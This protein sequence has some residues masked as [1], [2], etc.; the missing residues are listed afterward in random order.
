MEKVLFHPIM[1][2]VLD[3]LRK[4]PVALLLVAL[5]L[6]YYA[7][8]S[9]RAP[10]LV[11][12]LSALGLI[13]LASYIGEGTEALAAHFGPRIGG[14]LNATFGNTAEL[15]I[16]YIALREGLL[17][18]VR[19]SITGSI[20]G[21]ILLVMGFSMLFGGFKFGKQKFDRSHVAS[22]AILLILA[23]LVLLMPS[24]L[25]FYIGDVNSPQVLEFSRRVSVVMILLY[26]VALLFS[27]K[28]ERPPLVHRP[29]NE[30]LVHKP[31]W[32][33]L[34]AFLVLGL[35]T[36]GAARLSEWLVKAVEPVVMDLGVSEMLLGVVII[37]IVGNVT[38][39]LVAVKVAMQDMMDLSLEIAISSSLQIALFVAPVL[40]LLSL[41][42]GNPMVLIFSTPELLFMVGGAWLTR[43]V[44]SD[45]ESNWF[46]GTMLLAWYLCIVLFY[47]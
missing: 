34:M 22:N 33:K 42:I 8:A 38:E 44:S 45:G 16:I 6:A 20:L 46:E 10:V 13:P 19:A 18:L 36:Y 12:S 37:P 43:H 39:H 7:E 9:H 25:S 21:N 29:V 4:K 24:I 2:K 35:S 30:A 47:L 32:S 1:I 15:I 28:F 14:L 3:Y 31:K 41:L 27:F 26:G 5:P 17:D 11:F 40:V 23:M